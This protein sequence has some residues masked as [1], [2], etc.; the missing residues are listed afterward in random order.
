M[1]TILLNDFKTKVSGNNPYDVEIG[2]GILKSILDELNEGYAIEI[3]TN[4]IDLF[5]LEN[6]FNNFHNVVKPLAK[7]RKNHNPIIINDEIDVKDLI[8]ALFKLFYDDIHPEEP[9]PSTGKNH[10]FIDFYIPKI[11]V[12]VEIKFGRKKMNH[13]KLLQELNEDIRHYCKHS[14]METLYFFIYDPNY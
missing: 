13:K 3:A 5:N 10:T 6:I 12:G 7:R 4:S 1:K 2:I 8:H 11:K 9:I 14:D